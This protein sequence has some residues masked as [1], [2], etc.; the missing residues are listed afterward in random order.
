[1]S[2]FIGFSECKLELHVVSCLYDVIKFY[3][4]II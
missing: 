3:M 4:D 2:Y 1:M